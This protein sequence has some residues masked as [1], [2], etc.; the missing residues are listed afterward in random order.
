MVHDYLSSFYNDQVGGR[1]SSK[2]MQ[3]L[4]NTFLGIVN[5]LVFLIPW[6]FIVLSKS[7]SLKSFISAS[8]KKTKAILAFIFSWVVLVIIMSGAVFKFYDRYLLPVIPLISLFFAVILTGSNTQIRKSFNIDCFSRIN[9]F[10]Y[11]ALIYCMQFLFWQ[12]KFYLQGLLLAE[13]HF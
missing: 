1:V 12:I 2:T 11:S 8:D 10:F 5:L 7:R 13:L 9:M 4:K 3:V 6:I